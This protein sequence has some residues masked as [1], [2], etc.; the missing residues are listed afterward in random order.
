MNIVSFQNRGLID[1]RAVR[2]FGV[3]AKGC[4]NPIGF[5]GTGMKYAIA[6]CLRLGCK[7]TLYRGKERFDFAT[8]NIAV[9]NSDFRIVT[10][11]DEEIGFTT[12]LGKT[13][14]PWQAFREIYCNALDE[15]GSVIDGYAD[16]IDDYTTIVITGQAFYSAYL[17][18]D[19]IVLSAAPRWSASRVQIHERRN[20]FG[21]Y[22]GIRA[23]KLEH[24]C[25]LTYNVLSNLDLTEDRTL[26][27]VYQF[28]SAIREAI[29]T[30]DDETLISRFL[31]TASDSFEARLD[32]QCWT[33]PSE[34]FLRTV[35][36]V[37][38]RNC[39]NPSALKLYKKHRRCELTPDAA[40]LNRV[41]EIQLTRAIR[42]CEWAGYRMN[43]YPIV[44]TSDLEDRVWGRAYEWKNYLNRSAFM[45]G[46]KIV[47]GTL[48][49]EYIHLRH[50]LLD[51]SRDLQNH[52]LN[53]LVSMGE[54]A[55]GE[56][57]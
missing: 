19:H 8:A 2:T 27:N 46:T 24:Q 31:T 13:W 30:S 53:A 23:G 42:F 22:R 36:R 25:E 47:A 18:R 12:D 45:A 50:G 15:G 4:D 39:A 3:S 52:L 56:P 44:V 51:E 38:F 32:L 5:F 29:I 41:E 43:D 57:L 54:L 40:P 6:I 14:E 49:E 34:T 11:N 35:E 55:K 26:K 48:I 16:A 33:D 7:V 10:M 21:Y 20:A 28:Y 1:M 37:G 9:R 17:E